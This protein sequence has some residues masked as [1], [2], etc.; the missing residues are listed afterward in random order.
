MSRTIE[1]TVY[2]FEELSDRA[3]EN[4]RNWWRRCESECQSFDFAWEDKETIANILGIE[5]K[6]RP[7]ELMNG[8]T[9]YEPAIHYSGFYSQ[10]DGASFEGSYSYSKGASK[11]I[12][13]YAGTDA[14]LHRIADELQKVQR[15]EFYRATARMSRGS[16][17]NFYPHSGT[18]SVD[19]QLANGDDCH[20]EGTSDKII[21]LMRA[22]AD[23][24]YCQLISEY[25]FIMSDEN[26]DESIMRNGYE[27]DENGEVI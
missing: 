27:F 24:I 7:V 17:S 10:G 1:K 13:A 2:K 4:A 3:K 12:R 21:Q 25:E 14:E 26:V 18:M 19:V 9:R 23:W 15:E 11:K 8:G 5:F 16:G 6:Q 20:V 22:F